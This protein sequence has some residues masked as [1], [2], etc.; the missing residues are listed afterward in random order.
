M[1]TVVWRMAARSGC[2][3][4]AMVFGAVIAA[5]IAL[6]APAQALDVDKV[7]LA[8]RDS[9]GASCPR[10][11]SATVWVH[12]DGPG[13]VKVR[14]HNGSGGKTGIATAQAVKGSGGGYLAKVK[15]LF[16]I[17]TDVHIRYRAEVVGLNK[18]S[19]WVPFKATCGPQVRTKTKTIGSSGSKPKKASE[20]GKK[21]PGVRTKSGTT[22]SSSGSSAK[23][24]SS[25]KPTTKPAGK[26][27]TKTAK[28]SN[29]KAVCGAP[30][31]ATRVAALTQATGKGSARAGWEREARKRHPNSWAKWENARN[32]KQSCTFVGTWNCT[33][34]AQPCAQ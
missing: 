29:A 23:K 24:A 15:N 25:S 16:T 17:S 18:F 10:N 30:I 22:S 6:V 21:K 20:L 7:Q 9:G 2:L 3:Q 27:A 34:T 8:L 33:V 19:N 13:T 4:A 32:R 5:V 11:A 31:S 14:I 28:K 12:T 26:Q 1:I